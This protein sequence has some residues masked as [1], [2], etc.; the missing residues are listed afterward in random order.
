M[1]PWLDAVAAG[2]HSGMTVD[3]LEAY[4]AEANR[5]IRNP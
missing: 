1:D 5:G 4:L 3:E 2:G